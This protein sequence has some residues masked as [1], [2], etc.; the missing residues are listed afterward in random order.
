MI[1]GG[2]IKPDM[3]QE[4]K[5]SV[6][7]YFSYFS[8]QR[9]SPYS[10]LLQKEAG[11]FPG[12]P[13]P[14]SHVPPPLNLLHI[15][16][17]ASRRPTHLAPASGHRHLPLELCGPGLP[18]SSRLPFRPRPALPRSA[19]YTQTPATP[20][21]PT[22][23][24]LTAPHCLPGAVQGPKHDHS[25]PSGSR[26]FSPLIHTHTCAHTCTRTR[27]HTMGVSVFYTAG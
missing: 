6:K 11:A 14:R 7:V 18:G 26:H 19:F 24:P 15:S 5:S 3:N 2:S 1:L 10:L 12:L 25:L 16:V 27:T 4:L 21:L 20:P 17:L 13:L 8:A 23:L 22:S 9:A